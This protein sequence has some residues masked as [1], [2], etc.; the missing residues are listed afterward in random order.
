MIAALPSNLKQASVLV[1]SV[2]V[3]GDRT[4]Y[5]HPAPIERLTVASETPTMLRVAGHKNIFQHKA[6]CIP[7]DTEWFEGTQRHDQF[8]QALDE[9]A[10]YLMRLGSYAKNLAAAGGIKQ[11]PNPLTSTVISCK[12]P[13]TDNGGLTLNL[14]WYLYTT[15]IRYTLVTHTPKMLRYIYPGSSYESITTQNDTFCCPDDAAWEQFQALRQAAITASNHLQDYLK[16]L[17]TYQEAKQDGRYNTNGRAYPNRVDEPTPAETACSG[18]IAPADEPLA[19]SASNGTTGAAGSKESSETERQSVLSVQPTELRPGDRGSISRPRLEVENTATVASETAVGDFVELYRSESGE[20][21][22]ETQ[23]RRGKVVETFGQSF[24]RVHYRGETF[25]GGKDQAQRFRKLPDRDPL[26]YPT[27]P[28]RAASRGEEVVVTAPDNPCYG[29]IFTVHAVSIFGVFRAD[30]DF[31]YDEEL[32]YRVDE[33]DPYIQPV[34]PNRD[35]A[36][37]VTLEPG[38]LVQVMADD[39][40]YEAIVTVYRNL[41][42]FEVE[43]DYQGL[44]LAYPRHSLRL[45]ERATPESLAYLASRHSILAPT[46]PTLQQRREDL[47]A[48]ID[49]IRQS[50]P[51]APAGAEWKRYRK[52]KTIGKGDHAQTVTYPTDGG[53]YYTVWHRDAIFMNQGKLVKSLQ[54]GTNGSDSY[55]DWQQ[56]FERRRAI[57][58]LQK[59]LSAISQ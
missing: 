57:K 24:L 50:G 31:F 51:V 16:Q 46:E 10:S 56:R 19:S 25:A 55:K 23:R 36:F 37:T 11:A 47:L 6:Y 22:P 52:T 13:E 15:E 44:L 58:Q 54:V 33:D 20:E 8:K 30:N 2:L 1:P 53:Y 28:V 7:S 48:Q 32:G 9:L 35:E 39:D 42:T 18:G 14:P 34:S 43:I 17:G 12:D 45:Y 40:L 59:E 49:R 3:I 26:P 5:Y 38:D 4:R 29:E 41:P 21:L 27:Q